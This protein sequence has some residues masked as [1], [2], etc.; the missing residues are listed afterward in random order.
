MSKSPVNHGDGLKW[1]T[2]THSQFSFLIPIPT[3]T[4]WPIIW[5]TVTLLQ[6]PKLNTPIQIC[7]RYSLILY[8]QSYLPPFT[9]LNPLSLLWGFGR[10]LAHT[11][12]WIHKSY[13]IIFNLIASIL[14]IDTAFI[15]GLPKRQLLILLSLLFSFSNKLSRSLF[16]L[17]SL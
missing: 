17:S 14:C 5:S 13:Y 3:N 7:N 15:I 1:K 9:L 12:V 2:N 6:K 11:F 8:C 10:T 4:M 16:T